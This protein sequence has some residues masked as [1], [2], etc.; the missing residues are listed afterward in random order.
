MNISGE[1]VTTRCL[2]EES[3]Y[4]GKG[5]EE[6]VVRSGNKSGG[7]LGEEWEKGEKV[8][9]W[10]RGKGKK[11]KKEKEKRKKERW[12][13]TMEGKKGQMRKGRR[14]RIERG[15]GKRG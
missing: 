10:K 2:H 8:K 12:G 14:K 15:P 4:K 5:N 13:K 3:I 7:G 9:G 1:Y 11:G 6:K